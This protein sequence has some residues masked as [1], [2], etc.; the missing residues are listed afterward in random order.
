MSPPQRLRTA[1][2]Y[3]QLESRKGATPLC[4]R[5]KAAAADA[6]ET[7]KLSTCGGEIAS[8]T[9]ATAKHTTAAKAKP[10]IE[11]SEP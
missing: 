9:V 6:Y 7:S 4:E 8:A 11:K 2:D 5:Q 1:C 3:A 10:L